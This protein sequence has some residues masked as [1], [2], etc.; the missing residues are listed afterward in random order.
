MTQGIKDYLQLELRLAHIRWI[1][2]GLESEQEHAVIDQM[3]QL[4]WKLTQ[5]EQTHLN[6]EAAPYHLISDSFA[7]NSLHVISQDVPVDEGA[8]HAEYRRY[9]DRSA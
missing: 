3:E 8:S 6:N 2:G 5:E 7:P 1:H 4:W 9:F